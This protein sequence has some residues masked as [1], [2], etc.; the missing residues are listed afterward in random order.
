[1]IKIDYIKINTVSIVSRENMQLVKLNYK[2]SRTAH[3]FLNVYKEE[4]LICENIPLALSSGKGFTYVL[5]PVQENEFTALWKFS[6]KE[7][8]ILYETTALWK[9]CREW[10]LN[11]MISSHTDIGLH[12]PQYIQRYNSSKFTDEAMKLCD[13]TKNDSDQYHYIMEGTWFL[14]NYGLDRSKE[15]K[16]KLLKDYLKKDKIGVCGGVAGNCIQLYGLEEMCRSTYERKRLEENWDVDS[17]TMTMID[18]NALPM[19]MIQPYV[20]AG[21]KNIIFAPNHWCPNLSTVWNMDTTLRSCPY[22]TNA[23]GGGSRVDVSYNSEL[24]MVFYW[25]DENNNRMFVWASTQYNYGSEIFGLLPTAPYDNYTLPKMMQC[26]SDNLPVLEEKYPYDMWF[27]ACYCDDQEPSLHLLN[28]IKAWNEEWKYPQF[29]TVGNPDKLFNEFKTRYNKEIPVLHGDITG[30]WYQL[31]T[32]VADF[33]TKKFDTDRLLPTAEKWATVAALTTNY[34][35]PEEDFRK[36]WDCLL[37]NDEHSY[38]ASGYQGRRVYETWLQHND[39]VDKAK[40]TAERELEK[41]L[42]SISDNISSEEK[43]TVVFNPT[44]Q[45]RTEFIEKD[46][47]NVLAEIAPFGY[48]VIPDSMLKD[49]EK[50]S[51]RMENVTAEN[52]YYKISFAPNGAISSIYD[53]ELRRELL[54]NSSYAANEIIYTKDNHK[55]FST[56]QKA[57]FEVLEENNR[58]VMTIK[59]F[60]KELQCDI[61]QEIILPNYEKRIDID[62]K[63]YHAKDMINNNRYY[64]YIYFAFPFWVE[65]AQRLCHLNGTVAEYAKSVT[66]HGTDVYMA[67]NEWCLSQNEEFGVALMMKDSQLVEFD[68]IHPD[69]TDFGDTGEGS[70]IFVYAA[71]DWLQMHVAGG[72]HLDYRFRFSITSFKGDYKKSHLLK[73]AERYTNPVN[74]VKINPQHGESETKFR[75]FLETDTDL[76]LICLKK[77][78]DSNGVIARFYGE[79]KEI[80]INNIAGIKTNVERNTIDEKPLEIEEKTK[81]FITYRL[82]KDNISVPVRPLKS[83]SYDENIPAPIGSYYTGLVT[84]PKAVFGENPGQLYLL[85]G[86]NKEENFSHYKLYRSKEENFPADESTFVADVYPEEY[87]VGRYVD[88][89]L[90]NHTLYH[91]RVCAV[92]K[93][94]VSGKISDVFSAYT[95]EIPD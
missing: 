5:L 72:S 85:W 34:T 69:K 38:G 14:N 26:I 52:S 77:A 91:Y 75:S 7:G 49:S 48:T 24:P 2:C 86:H 84:K 50:V 32:S 15:E 70:Q 30:G 22:S 81:G 61:V 46:G 19:S 47:K 42:R 57:E 62:N 1:M 53:K 17:E 73:M 65:N 39:W 93:N 27:S 29:K 35:Y 89:E 94:G 92:N 76:R 78:D 55:S 20:Q 6:D 95:R 21:Y 43:A 45:K 79:E 12:N 37:Y 8:N 68:R 10:T 23:G 88:T 60:H 74:T 87:V 83:E 36:A 67:V 51:R 4:K 28:S 66:E 71:N 90:E 11:L 64:R 16:E 40:E 54:D 3:I 31:A 82:G 80:R 63:I 25:E 41:A 9:K 18:N 59:S 44:L 13:E 33:L 56:V 58:T